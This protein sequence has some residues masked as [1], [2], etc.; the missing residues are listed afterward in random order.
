MAWTESDDTPLSVL[1]AFSPLSESILSSLSVSDS[2]SVPHLP[3]TLAPAESVAPQL[4]HVPLLPV[5]AS[6][7]PD[8]AGAPGAFVGCVVPDDEEGAEFSCSFDALFCSELTRTLNCVAACATPRISIDIPFTPFLAAC[9]AASALSSL[10]SRL[11]INSVIVDEGSWRSFRS[12]GFL[13]FFG[14]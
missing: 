1:F 13:P 2:T 5:D 8:A 11:F 7:V 4:L 3:Q 9:Y 12:G 14:P 10:L 6:P